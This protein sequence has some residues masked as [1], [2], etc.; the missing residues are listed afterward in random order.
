MVLLAFCSAVIVAGVDAEAKSA[1]KKSLDKISG[2][3]KKEE[4]RKK[5]AAKKEAGRMYVENFGTGERKTGGKYYALELNGLAD[6]DTLSFKCVSGRCMTVTL[7]G[8]SSSGVWNTLYQGAPKDR[9]VG[10]VLSGKRS[11]Y[12]H[13]IISVN[14]AHERYT[15]VA[16]KMEV[17]VGRAEVDKADDRPTMMGTP[18]YH[19]TPSFQG[20]PGYHGTPTFQGTPGYHGTPSFQGT[21]GYYGT[22]R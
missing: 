19:G 20:T 12:T 16:A 22:P 3:D 6:G 4:R 14:G 7:H 1:F 13:I 2:K 18:S 21:P 15:K 17:I 10:S 8:R 9:Q 5:E 11:R